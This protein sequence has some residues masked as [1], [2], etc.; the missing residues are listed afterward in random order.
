MKIQLTQPR[1]LFKPSGNLE[2]QQEFAQIPFGYVLDNKL[3]IVFASRQARDANGNYKSFPAQ[4]LFDL[5][6]YSLLSVTPSPLMHVGKPGS[7]DEFG[8]M[9]GSIIKIPSGEV[10][11]YYCGW[12]RSVNTPYRWSIGVAYLGDDG[13]FHRRYTGPVI[14]QSIEHPYLTASPVVSY[15]AYSGYEMFHL[16]GISWDLIDNNYEACYKITRSHSVDGISWNSAEFSMPNVFWEKECQT[17]PNIIEISEKRFMTFCYRSQN[18]FREDVNQN[19]KTALA[20]EITPNNWTIIQT[21]IS[22]VEN[23]SERFDIAYLHTFEYSGNFYGL[24]NYSMGFGKSG[25]YLAN[26]EILP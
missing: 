2:W 15:S 25:I 3:K 18:R 22:V 10:V 24:Y 4:A 5:E 13:V 11:M 19:Y 16:T 6:N 8:V 9:P 7:F 1:L 20:A 12:S 26:L 14:G 21:S 17:S 23:N